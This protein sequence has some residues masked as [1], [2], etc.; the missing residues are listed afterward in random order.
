[1]EAGSKKQNPARGWV[2]FK[3]VPQTSEFGYVTGLGTFL[4]LHD[5]KLYL[6]AFLQAFI[7][8]GSDGAVV[9]KNVRAVVTT[10][11]PEAFGIVKPFNCSFNT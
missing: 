4:A 2:C 1:V 5:L 9:N 3:A 11:E 6:V 10:D 7:A 8:F